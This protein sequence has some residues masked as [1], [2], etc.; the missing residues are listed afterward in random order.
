MVM[1]YGWV[2]GLP[3]VLLQ[4]KLSLCAGPAVQEDSHRQEI[5]FIGGLKSEGHLLRQ[6]LH[7]PRALHLSLHRWP[8][9]ECAST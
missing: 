8:A 3:E 9:S 6:G 2:G 1:K 4:A 7:L 5:K